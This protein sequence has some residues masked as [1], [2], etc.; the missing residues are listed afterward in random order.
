MVCYKQEKNTIKEK[1]NCNV[2]SI[3]SANLTTSL[4]G[5]GAGSGQ[6]APLVLDYIHNL[7]A[8]VWIGEFSILSLHYFQ[9]F[10][11]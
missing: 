7:V 4:I 3:T 6:T 5:H 10:H 1:P 9:H 11:N 8:A 2:G